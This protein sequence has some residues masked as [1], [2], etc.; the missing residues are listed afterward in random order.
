MALDPITAGMDLAQTVV[1]RIFPDKTAQ[2][3]QQLAAVLSMIQGQMDSNKAQASNPS[4]FV[5]GARPFIMWVCG[6]ACAWNWIGISIAKTV[7]AVLHYP[8]VLTPADIS[9]MMPML[10]ALLGLG[11]YRTVEKLKGVA[12]N[13]LAD[14]Q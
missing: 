1:S 6:I 4:V 14:T 7:C 11:A 2:E 10:T 5:S 8:I 3:Q 9:E 13:S 12:R